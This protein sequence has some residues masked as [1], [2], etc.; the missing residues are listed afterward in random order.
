[1][2]ASYKDTNCSWNGKKQEF[3]L[4]HLLP[5]QIFTQ[6]IIS[7]VKKGIKALCIILCGISLTILT[8][9]GTNCSRF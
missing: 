6:V 2:A 4:P 3:Y 7:V 8:K 5:V 1:M 9:V